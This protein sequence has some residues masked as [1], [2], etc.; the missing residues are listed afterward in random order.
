[1][2][3]VWRLTY[4]EFS[5][6]FTGD[7]PG[8]FEDNLND[9]KPTTILKVAHHGSNYSTTEEFLRQVQPKLSVISC[10]TTNR[11]GHPGEQTLER[12]D[13]YSTN[14]GTTSSVLI[15]K[16]CGAIT[17]RTDGRE[18]E[19]ETYLSKTTK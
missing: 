1:M 3:L 4:K 14:N 18:V 11:Y 5:M 9:L 17:I 16:D 12:L 7:L 19:V 2:S 13:Q 10:S 15:T 8:E 6:L